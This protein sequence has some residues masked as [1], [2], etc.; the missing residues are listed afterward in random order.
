[1]GN[2]INVFAI[3][4]DALAALT[5]GR[6]KQYRPPTWSSPAQV[7]M[8][9]AAQYAE[10]LG[11]VQ[12]QQ[13]VAAPIFDAQGNQTSAP[14]TSSVPNATPLFLVFDCT[15]RISHSQP[16]TATEHPIQD[17]ANQTD[18]IKANQ[19]RISIE[20]VMSDVMPAYAAGQWVG[21]AS[22]SL[23][24][25]QTLDNIRLR[26]IPVT[27]TTRLK[28]Y[29]NVFI[30]DVLPEEDVRSQHGF[31]GRIE[32]KQIFLASVATLTVSARPQSTD[33]TQQGSVNPEAV[34]AGVQ[35]QNGVPDSEAIQAQSGTV[36][37]AG[38]FSSN[39]A[40]SLLPAGSN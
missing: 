40:T 24:C 21:N 35:A 32:F 36:I 26:R 19:A 1:M 33:S 4:D 25:F 39:N 37:G 3:A 6:G 28:T 27:L 12:P 23:A 18:H 9:V 8:T 38:D 22:K 30:M 29:N 17:S 20:V 14:V 31:R 10:A 16:M 2:L 13:Q 11:H 34:P 15:P 5:A 7:M